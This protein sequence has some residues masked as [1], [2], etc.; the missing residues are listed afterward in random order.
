[1]SIEFYNLFISADPEAWE[2]EFYFLERNRC[3]EHTAADL[4]ERFQLFGS[5][6]IEELK[7]VPCIFAYENCVGKDACIGYITELMVRSEQIRVVFEKTGT[8][9]A[10]QIRTMKFELDISEWE[11]NRTHWAL[12]RVDLRSLLSN[13]NISFGAAS[14]PN[15][16]I[17]ITMHRFDVAVTFAGEH[18]ELVKS[19]VDELNNKLGDNKVFY[20]KNY[21]SQLARPSLDALLQGIYR[22][23]AKLVVVF[24]GERYQEKKWC[25]LEFRVVKEII[26]NK[27]VERIMF[28]KLDDGEVDG[29]LQTDGY[30]NGM[31][32]TPIELAKFICERVALLE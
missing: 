5:T 30:I 19:I 24:L 1:V 2:G 3:F 13:L 16:P 12:K 11:L 21:Q 28:I 4:K 17:D 7:R 22:N 31:D 23:Q 8:I 9:A 6:E 18:R 27:E 26:L 15:Q 14:T 20:D 29:V 32:H 25:G 10:D